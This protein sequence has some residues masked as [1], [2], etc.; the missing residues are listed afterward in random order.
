MKTT[1]IIALFLAVLMC[2]SMLVPTGA[3]DAADAQT[4]AE[5]LKVLGLFNG[6]DKGFELERVPTR[7]EAII[8]LIRMTGKENDALYSEWENP[9]TDAP[10]WENA[11][12]YL[13]YAYEN[14]LTT[15]VSEG[16]FDPDS[17]ASAQMYITFMLRALGYADTSDATV[18][19]NWEALAKDA[20]VLPS[21]VNTADFTRGDAVLVSYAALSASMANDDATLAETLLALGTFNDLTYARAE[22][23]AGKKVTVDS[24]LLDIAA[25]LYTDSEIRTNYLYASE[26][27]E[28]NISYF[29]GVDSLD[30]AQAIAVEPMMTS[31]AHS[32]CVIRMNKASDASKAADAIK[33]NVNPRKW[34]CVGVEP[35][36]VHTLCVDD[37]VILIMDNNDT[38]FLENFKKIEK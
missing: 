5:S 14:G 11:A 37:L 26:I 31:S 32:I 23:K 3:Y 13:G 8:M 6:T 36:H 29:L 20:K 27:N 15:G 35:E 7:M 24:D 22:I 10:T 34:V 1:K 21:G 12:Q 25:L 19:D 4:K 9:F 16:K 33:E 2:V 30:F 28:D 18:W 38:L 17:T